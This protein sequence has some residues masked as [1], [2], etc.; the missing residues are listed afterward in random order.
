MNTIDIAG[1][2]LQHQQI[3]DVT[4][5]NPHDV[6]QWLGAVQA[7][8]Y[9]GALWSLGLRTRHATERTI[10]AAIANKSIIRTWP[11]R[12]TLHFVAAEDVRWMLELLT[13]RVIARSATRYRQLDLNDAVFERSQDLI[14]AAL[15]GGKHLSRSALYQVLEAAK[16]DTSGQRGIHILGHLAQHGLICFGPRNGKQP[17]FALLAEWAPQTKLMDRDAALAE[18]TRRYFTGH[19]PATVQDFI[20]WSGLTAADAKA[21]LALVGS[22]LIHQTIDGTTYWMAHSTTISS[23]SPSI[24]I[25]PGFDEYLLGYTDRS[26]MLDPQHTQ[27]VHPGNNG[28]FSPTIV[29]DGRVVGTWRRTL[30]Q[31]SVVVTP[32]P[33]APLTDTEHA[34]LAN[35]AQHYGTFLELPVVLA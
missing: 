4:F 6:V 32:L 35:A 17:T 28:M 22:Q 5:T 33:F 27:H 19:G 25:L 31:R 24:Y 2:R 29:C 26:V 11:M 15:Q 21:G 18:L 7:Q 12:G 10:E 13:A 3:G 20:W 8:D 30:K 16:I 1:Q 9:L 14:S 34:A 23:R